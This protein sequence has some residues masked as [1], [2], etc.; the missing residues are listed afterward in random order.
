MRN[1]F[2]V[3]AQSCVCEKPDVC[4]GGS[5]STICVK[6]HRL[7]AYCYVLPPTYVI[8]GKGKVIFSV[9]LST[10]GEG[11]LLDTGYSSVCEVTG[12]PLDWTKGL[13]V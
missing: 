3:S 6:Q 4:G 1:G 13:D 5:Q 9:C 11:Y 10:G 12:V 2:S 8:R 7:G